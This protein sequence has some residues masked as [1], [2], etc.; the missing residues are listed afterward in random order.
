MNRIAQLVVFNP[1]NSLTPMEQA[2]V[3]IGVKDGVLMVKAPDTAKLLKGFVSPYDIPIAKFKKF[4]LPPEMEG[5]RNLPFLARVTFGGTG[6]TQGLMF[7]VLEASQGRGEVPFTWMAGE[8]LP[9]LYGNPEEAVL[10]TSELPP[11]VRCE[12]TFPIVLLPDGRKAFALGEG[13]HSEDIPA[14]DD[15]RA[16]EWLARQPGA[17]DRWNRIFM[18]VRVKRRGIRGDVIGTVTTTGGMGAFSIFSVPGFA[19]SDKNVQWLAADQFNPGDSIRIVFGWF[20]KEYPVVERFKT[21]H[22]RVG[23]TPPS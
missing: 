14:H 10:T 7:A 23:L 2:H 8:N 11:L 5:R 21:C 3:W 18:N 6:I 22:L 12:V 15:W 1:L 19:E 20:G 16:Q 17:D 4:H 13:W 9:L